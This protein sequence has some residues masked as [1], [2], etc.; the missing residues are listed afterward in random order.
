MEGERSHLEKM[1]CGGDQVADDVQNIVVVC[2]G[3][4]ARG[5]GRILVEGS[6][7][8]PL[9]GLPVFVVYLLA[10]AIFVYVYKRW[11]ENDEKRRSDGDEMLISGWIAWSLGIDQHGVPF[12]CLT[13]IF[14]HNYA[15]TPFRNV[16]T[17]QSS[18]TSLVRPPQ[19]LS[20]AR[21]SR[22]LNLYRRLWPSKIGCA[23][24]LATTTSFSIIVNPVS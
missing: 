19:G 20:M 12:L 8:G 18:V 23:T 11:E 15:G 2:G 17:W 3:P 22:L 21:Q 7:D 6:I 4:L 13:L 24:N 14:H 9:S 10:P 16:E 5:R 1:V